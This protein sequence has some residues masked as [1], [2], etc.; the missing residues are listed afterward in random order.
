[1]A[2]LLQYTVRLSTDTEASFTSVERLTYYSTS[3]PQEP[4]TVGAEYTPSEVQT[5]L[6]T[7]NASMAVDVQVRAP[8]PVN[9]A[10][11]VAHAAH[12]NRKVA[13]CGV[14]AWYPDA[15]NQVL[16][17]AQW[18]VHG[19]LTLE[20]VS[21][22]YR[23][24]LPLVLRDI[25][26]RI[27]PHHKVGVV[28]RTGSG[29]STL[30]L[31]CFRMLECDSGR[32]TLDGLDIS[33]V[34]VYQL[35][36]RCAVIPQDP[37][38][39]TGTVRSNL[40][41]FN[42]Y[43]DDELWAVLT[44][45]GMQDFVKCHPKGLLRPVSEAGGNMSVGER[46]LLCLARA[47]LRKARLIFMDEAT[48][49]IDGEN[50]ANIQ[51]AM[52]VGMRDATVIVIAHRLHTIMDCDRVLVMDAGSVIE[53]DAPA[54]LLGLAAPREAGMITGAFK[55]MLAQTGPRT[56]SDLERMVVDAEAARGIGVAAAL[57]AAATMETSATHAADGGAHDHAS[58]AK[59][60]VAAT[61]QDVTVAVD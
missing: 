33:R 13:S 47:L 6:A 60:G 45:A 37:T 18:P 40:D 23:A 29:K 51:R 57:D 36:S 20:G 30:A 14:T 55:Q 32:I 39:Y 25:T 35:R 59:Q 38:L 56:S 58:S 52:R 15:W 61:P 9:A 27:H 50:D 12:M 4:V 7:V 8:A 26:L 46:Q 11:S 42:E 1:M 41:V 54:A 44:A 17:S 28:G 43:S 53:Y 22:R 5:A 21:V 49:N 31:T 2:G 16:A 34:N 24:G 3:V 10:N 48:A 19:A